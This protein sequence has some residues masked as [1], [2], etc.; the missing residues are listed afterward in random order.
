MYLQSG[1]NEIQSLTYI[2]IRKLNA[3]VIQ[4]QKVFYSDIL[5]LFIDGTNCKRASSSQFVTEKSG[6]GGRCITDREPKT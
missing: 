6:K 1:H 2:H 5:T 3:M 4:H